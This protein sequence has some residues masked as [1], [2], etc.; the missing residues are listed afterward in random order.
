MGTC[1]LEP[2]PG[3]KLNTITGRLWVQDQKSNISDVDKLN[4]S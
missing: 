1:D 4:A 2:Q 3:W